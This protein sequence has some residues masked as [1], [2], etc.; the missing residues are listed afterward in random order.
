M[1]GGLQLESVDVTMLLNNNLTV[2]IIVDE[3]MSHDVRDFII[4]CSIN[5]L[6]AP[7]Y[8]AFPHDILPQ[9]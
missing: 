8:I 5:S 6:L 7:S 2:T 9:K 3:A 1:E 4:F